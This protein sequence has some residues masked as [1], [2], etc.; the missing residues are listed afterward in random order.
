[1]V[2]PGESALAFYSAENRSSTPI[3]GVSTY[4]ITPMKVLIYIVWSC[5][6]YSYVLI[7]DYISTF[8]RW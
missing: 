4:N 6:V 7:H 5:I 2:K 3:T 1:M 8:K